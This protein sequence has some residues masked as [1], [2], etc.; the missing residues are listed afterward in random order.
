MKEPIP[1]TGGF[2]HKMY[3]VFTESGRYAIKA[4]NPN[5]M[6]RKEA[7]NNYIMSERIASKLSA[8]IKVSCANCYNEGYIQEVDGQFYLIYDFI[9]GKSLKQCEITPMHAYKIGAV[10]ANIHNTDFSEL[11]IVNDNISEKQ[12]FNWSSYL[13]QGQKSRMEW[14][15][16]L[17]ENTDR[18]SSLV[19]KMNDAKAILSDNE[20]ICHGDLD[21]KNVLWDNDNPIIIDWESSWYS[22]PYH[23][24]LETALYWSQNPDMS[25]KYDVFSA[26]F[27]GY[28]SIRAMQSVDWQT[29][30]YSGYSAKLG[31]LEYNLKRSLGIECADEA[32][33]KLGMEQAVYTLNEILNYEKHNEEIIQYLH[34][35][36]R[37]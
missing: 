7:Y 31:W 22:N 29:V 3:D 11:N 18:L 9:D 10:V 12:V 23:D 17:K 6:E 14:H 37:E 4:L 1:I 26:F 16:L 36:L 28:T 8:I 2:L 20:I 35:K 34:I 5:I 15:D 30:L 21:P 19:D 13:V 32:E 27:N 24:F 25:V 33:Q